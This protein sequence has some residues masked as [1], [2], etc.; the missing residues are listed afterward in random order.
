MSFIYSLEQI[1]E[2]GS[3]NDSRKG[4][5]VANEPT[6]PELALPLLRSLDPTRAQL[7]RT[8]LGRLELLSREGVSLMMPE[9]GPGR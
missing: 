3:D 7:V 8:A 9:L 4:F 2:D 5:D 6:L 1:L